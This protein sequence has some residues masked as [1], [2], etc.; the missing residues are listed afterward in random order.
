MTRLAWPALLA[1]IL[2]AALPVPL[3]ASCSSAVPTRAEL[4]QRSIEGMRAVCPFY[5]STLAAEIPRTPEL[6]AICAVLIPPPEPEP[7]VTVPALPVDAGLE[8]GG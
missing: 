4:A 8:G 6:D 1:A 2:S 7:V 3:L 5:Q